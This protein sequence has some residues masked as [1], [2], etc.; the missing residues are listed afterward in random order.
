MG[1]FDFI[2]GAIVAPI[3]CV[4]MTTGNSLIALG[5]WPAH[6]V[7][8]YF[9][10]L[11][12]LILVFFYFFFAVFKRKCAIIF[13]F[14]F[15]AKRLGPVMKVVVCILVALPLAFWPVCVVVG[16]IIGGLAYGFLGPVFGTFKAVSEGK[17]D[18]FRHCFIV[19][20]PNKIIPNFVGS[21][22]SIVWYV[23]RDL[24]YNQVEFNIR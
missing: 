3:V 11:R 18:K 10:I 12:S 5:L 1:I 6:A 13:R 15:S 7:W 2:S 20:K 9:C 4:L 23:G 17:T 24:G 19:S 21:V 14:I 16:S 22:D 8:A